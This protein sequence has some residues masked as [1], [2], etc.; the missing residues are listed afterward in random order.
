M[1]NSMRVRVKLFAVA[2]QKAGQDEI[3]VELPAA[4]TV[5]LLRAAMVEQFPALADVIRHVRFAVDNEYAGDDLPLEP[6]AEIA[7]IPPVSG[8]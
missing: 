8:G 4:A 1:T 6:S 5:A 3:E 2:K 7:V